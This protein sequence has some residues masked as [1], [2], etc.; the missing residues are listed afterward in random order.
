MTGV[1]T[2]RG[3]NIEF[4]L[5]NDSWSLG[6]T[7]QLSLFNPPNQ[8]IDGGQINFDLPWSVG[9]YAL[10]G[11]SPI[12][13]HQVQPA[14]TITSRMTQYVVSGQ[15]LQLA[16][17][18]TVAGVDITGWQVNDAGT[19]L[20]FEAVLNQ[21]GIFNLVVS[22]T[23]QNEVL[24]AAVLVA[25][26]LRIDGI[27]SDNSA[28][29]D[30]VSDS[31]FDNITVSGGGFA[32][33]LNVHFYED[34]SGFAPH[35]QNMVNHRVDSSGIHFVSPITKPGHRYLVVISRD[36]TFERLTSIGRFT[37]IDDTRP[38]VNSVTH[39]GYTQAVEISLNEAA[40]ADGFSVIKSF[41][42]YSNS[43]DIDVSSR[44]ELQAFGATL[45]LRLKVGQQL[46]NNA[47][48][49]ISIN[50]IG[51]SAGNTVVDSTKISAGIYANEFIATDLLSPVNLQLSRERDSQAVTPGMQLTRGRIYVFHPVASDNYDANYGTGK[52]LDYSIRLSTNGGLNFGPYQEVK[53]AGLEVA[54]AEHFANLAFMVKA[55]DSQGNFVT[56]RFDVTVIDPQIDIAAVA[57]NPLQVEELTR[58]DILFDISG[59]ADLVT[60]VTIFLQGRT[61]DAGFSLTNNTLAQVVHSY[62]NPRMADI[63]PAT[64]VTVGLRVSYG[65]SGVKVIEDSYQLYLDATPPT[66][67]IVSPQNGDRIA[68]DDTTDILIQSFDK[69]GIDKVEVSENG[70]AFVELAISNRHQIMATSTEPFTVQVRAIDP[71]GNIGL[72]EIVTMAP[73]DA[74]LGEPKV[75][76][77]SPENGTTYHEGQKVEFDVLLQNLTTATL[78][79]DV[80]GASDDSRNPAPLVITRTEDQ[81]K[82]F[83]VST[84][85]PLTGENVVV[86]ARLESGALNAK[87]FIN[88]V[89]DEGIEQ[90]AS[91]ELS[92]Q[93]TVLGGTGLWVSAQ[94]PA[95]MNDFAETSM[96]TVTDGAVVTELPMS[97]ANQLVNVTSAA[98]TVSVDAKLRDL[99]N[100][101]VTK[102]YL[103]NKP[104]YLTDN[105]QTIY[106]ATGSVF[107]ITH[108][109]DIP[110]LAPAYVLNDSNAGY[111]IRLNDAVLRTSAK[112]E[113]IELMFSGT[114]LAAVEVTDGD[115]RL[116]YWPIKEQALST[117][118]EHSIYGDLV[119]VN[120]PT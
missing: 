34:A 11:L 119:G 60:G 54:V 98:G 37:A 77:Y 71:N 117:A 95:D 16:Q 8:H 58:A 118:I 79:F 106:S 53:S 44:F 105:V 80:G 45:T 39:L 70:G 49:Q 89:K 73:F 85:L 114:G 4:S 33:S 115:H 21:P 96:V 116:L 87:S 50:G 59:D 109:V 13:L 10:F 25:E 64:R 27:S 41:N 9:T 32:G 48:Y 82:R 107:A 43:A 108:L 113:I 46:D 38:V 24:P 3:N 17:S 104:A 30:K 26:A 100:H 68:L 63:E 19:E 110:G 83:I 112:G 23:G 2:T 78:Y 102:Q 99:S 22:Q 29:S 55:V 91:A 28:G 52:N 15:Q 93:T 86:L 14:N 120:G 69:Y 57:T 18:V 94:A 103:L 67:K 72:S 66:V 40:T 6:E 51:D 84:T 42:D 62:L 81:P 61:Y 31:G 56:G 36:A 20:T 92:P 88:V 90:Q 35:S 1:S 12:E 5:N 65:F 97:A 76:I 47:S 74:S 75:A 111:E 101:Q 7:Y